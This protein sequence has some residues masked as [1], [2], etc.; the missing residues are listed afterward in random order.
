MDNKKNASELVQY[1]A[2][3][4]LML[5]AAILTMLCAMM[6]TMSFAPL[7]EIIAKDIGVDLGTASFGFMGMNLFSTAVGVML[8]GFLIDRIGLSRVMIGGLILMLAAN[9]ALPVI[10]H[11]YAAVVL[12]RILEALG[13]APALIIIEPTVSFWFP[14]KE[15]GLA[16]GLNGLSILGPVGT[17]MLGP[18]LV[19]S[20][21]SWQM[22]ML[23]F[24]VVLLVATIFI[25]IVNIGARHH[26]PP[27]MT[28]KEEHSNMTKQDF[29]RTV[30]RSPAFWLGLCVMAFSTWAN[31]SFNNLSPAFLAVDPPVGAGYGAEAAG[32]F[33]A[34]TWIGMIGG[35]FL[36]G[37]IIDKV[38]RGRTAPLV[39][40]GFLANLILYTGILFQAVN[41][42]PAI[43]T[44]WLMMAGITNPFTAVGNQCFAVRTFSPEVIGKVAAI[45]ICV[46]NFAG[47]IGVMTAS[48]A[49]KSTGNYHLAFAVIAGASILGLAAAIISREKRA[50]IEAHA[51]SMQ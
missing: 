7:V 8:A 34:G 43:L 25:V 50:Q 14:N 13:C 24:S 44:V 2:Y 20:A 6:I 31:Q 45:W 30:L 9:T 49:L 19:M 15:K 21:S 16:L 26:L 27:T 32:R 4:W 11:S 41:G 36:S 38:C 37:F 48:L 47:S 51:E 1:P 17:G 28:K 5:A 46:S 10:G 29:M 18:R 23:Y 3:R 42:S 39:I 33:S 22:G 40:F 12:I 35:F